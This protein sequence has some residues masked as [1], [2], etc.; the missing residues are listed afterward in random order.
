MPFSFNGTSFLGSR[1]M[2]GRPAPTPG[3]S[4]APAEGKLCEKRIER[5]TGQ[6]ISFA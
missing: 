2:P 4:R 1:A 3:P 5:M 6:S